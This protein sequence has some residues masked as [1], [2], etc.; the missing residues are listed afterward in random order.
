MMLT[1]NDLGAISK[2][3]FRWVLDSHWYNPLTWSLLTTH[4]MHIDAIDVVNGE[5]EV[6]YVVTVQYQ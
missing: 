6:R 2:V 1:S 4:A 5:T 3:D